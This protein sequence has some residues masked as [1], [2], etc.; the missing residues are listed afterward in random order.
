MKEGR[1]VIKGRK[2]GRK[3]GY[4]SKTG[5]KGIGRKEGRKETRVASLSLRLHLLFTGKRFPLSS[6]ALTSSPT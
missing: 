4:R 3:E 2:E 1:S 5:R 6:S